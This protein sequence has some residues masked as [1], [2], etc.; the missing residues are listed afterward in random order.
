MNISSDNN[1]NNKNDQP[2]EE[3]GDSF[4]DLSIERPGDA[5]MTAEVSPDAI[6][7][8]I[9]EIDDSFE[10]L[11]IFPTG[12]GLRRSTRLMEAYFALECQIM[13]QRGLKDGR[14]YRVAQAE[15]GTILNLAEQELSHRAQAVDASCC[16]TG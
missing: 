16:E 15:Q 6:D 2:V 3:I 5:A 11:L 7:E 10:D 14:Q 13:T 9:E 12:Q 8:K 4:V 1:N